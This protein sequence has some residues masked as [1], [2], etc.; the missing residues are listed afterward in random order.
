MCLGVFPL[1]FERPMMKDSM[2]I[3]F[4]R[5]RADACLRTL[6]KNIEE[7]LGLPTGSFKFVHPNGRKARGMQQSQRCAAAGIA[8]S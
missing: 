4:R 7:L 3:R 5:A 2:P 1:Y 6:Q 8:E